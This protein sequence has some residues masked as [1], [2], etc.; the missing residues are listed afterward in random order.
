MDGIN[1]FPSREKSQF[2]FLNRSVY[3][4]EP[5]VYFINILTSLRKPRG[6]SLPHW[7]FHSRLYIIS[8]EKKHLHTKGQKHR[9]GSTEGVWQKRHKTMGRGAWWEER[10]ANV[11]HWPLLSEKCEQCYLLLG[12]L[13][14][15]QAITTRKSCVGIITPGFWHFNLFPLSVMQFTSIM[16]LWEA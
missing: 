11:S 2:Y 16:C 9:P 4:P 12:G 6:E 8:I 15:I 10:P 5:T 14:T 13:K 1:G 3:N 7:S